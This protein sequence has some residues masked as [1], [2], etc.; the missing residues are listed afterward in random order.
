MYQ[1]S[2]KVKTLAF[3]NEHALLV[4][5]GCLLCWKKGYVFSFSL[6]NTR[7]V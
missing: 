1:M 3:F 5:L 6:I 7:L 2:Q 4:N